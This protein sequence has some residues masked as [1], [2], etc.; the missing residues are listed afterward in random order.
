[1]DK[2]SILGDAI[3]FVKELK[4]Q[5]KE[6]QDEL[7]Q[8]SDDEGAKINGI[9]GNKHNTVQGIMDCIN[10]VNL[11]SKNKNDM[12]PINFEVGKSC[13]GSISKQYQDSTNANDK[14]QQMEVGHSFSL[15]CFSFTYF[16][17]FPEFLRFLK[18]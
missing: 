17:I 6:L 5:A 2:A 4:K 13:N 10:G 12:V 14:A 7:E 11:G 8:H 1:M 18:K 3:E 16:S 15:S 9:N